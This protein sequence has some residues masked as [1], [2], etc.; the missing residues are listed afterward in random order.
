V[1]R[2]TA[3]LETVVTAAGLLKLIKQSGNVAQPGKND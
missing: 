3:D 1:G 2:K